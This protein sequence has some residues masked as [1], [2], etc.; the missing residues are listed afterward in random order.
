MKRK[1][2]KPR[3]CVLASF[4][5]G[6]EV[7]SY[8]VE[9]KYSINFVGTYFRDNSVYENKITKLCKKNKIKLFRKINAND[10]NFIDV[11]SNN[12][13]DIVILAW[14]PDIIKKESIQIARIGWIN[15]HPSYLPY[16]RGKHAYF[17]SIVENTPFGVSIHFID[18]GIDSGDILFQKQIPVSILD[19]GETLYEKGVREVI[20]LFKANCD[21]IM[22]LDLHPVKQSRKGTNHFAKD[23]EEI[24]KIDLNKKYKAI[25]LINILRARSFSNGPSSFFVL[26][27]DKY[28]IKI[29]IIK[30]TKDKSRS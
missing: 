27:D 10:K 21:K 12:E 6:F 7:L 8:I 26:D 22:T 28:L 20:D 11:L 1:K 4:G 14:W 19:T 16:G 24:S 5:Q 15:L 23:I 13:I 18:E 9:R 30:D 29:K 25:D 2:N 3:V 17:W